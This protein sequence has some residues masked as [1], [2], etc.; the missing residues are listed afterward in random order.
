MKQLQEVLDLANIN[1]DDERHMF[2]TGINHL[3]LE[4]NT[5]IL[6]LNE[7]LNSKESTIEQINVRYAQEISRLKSSIENLVKERAS[8]QLKL[9]DLNFQLES[10]GSARSVEAQNWHD[11]IERISQDNQNLQTQLNIALFSVEEFKQKIADFIAENNNLNAEVSHLKTQLN[12][13]ME[14][15]QTQLNK[16]QILAVKL[17]DLALERD[18]SEDSRRFLERELQEARSQIVDFEIKLTEN[19]QAAVEDFHDEN[20]NSS[21]LQETIKKLREE[22]ASLQSS[23]YESEKQNK[24]FSLE[25]DQLSFKADK[26]LQELR[27]Q[28]EDSITWSSLVVRERDRLS[29]QFDEKLNYSS[30]IEII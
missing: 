18:R 25:L 3:K 29:Q 4:F 21:R 11:E 1:L 15:N 26:E 19:P 28:L 7:S 2:E 13:T 5:K 22:I 16:V 8:S 10:F 12:S 30:V 24:R 14:A 27:I 17:K 23:N 9:D 20:Q 6:N